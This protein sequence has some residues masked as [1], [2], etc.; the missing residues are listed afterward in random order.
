MSDE[1]MRDNIHMSESREDS[2]SKGKIK[3][4]KMEEE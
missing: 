1:S 4:K 2:E 3:E